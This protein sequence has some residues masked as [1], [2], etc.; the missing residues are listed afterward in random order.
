MTLP[1]LRKGAQSRRHLPLVCAAAFLCF[2]GPAKWSTSGSQETFAGFTW[3]SPVVPAY[4][5]ERLRRHAS[6]EANEASTS[7][8]PDA[9]EEPGASEEADA[10][11]K[12]DA[13]N[14]EEAA[15][16][17]IFDKM[18]TDADGLIEEASFIKA[19]QS[20]GKVFDNLS[21]KELDELFLIAD[22]D[23][24]CLINFADFSKWVSAARESLACFYLVDSD[25]DGCI[26]REEWRTVIEKMS[27]DLKEQNSGPP[28]SESYY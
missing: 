11:K 20:L 21:E 2:F 8:E 1:S 27:L 4:Q 28:Y 3:H 15:L 12:A 23:K 7:Q 19:M 25:S 13:G 26:T 9:S 18:D 10:S 17:A 5:L 14:D 24:D 22:A 16:R 6:E